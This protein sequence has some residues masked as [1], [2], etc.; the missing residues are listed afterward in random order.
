[1]APVCVGLRFFLSGLISGLISGAL[2]AAIVGASAAVAG[3]I[4]V[5]APSDRPFDIGA[6]EGGSPDCAPDCRIFTDD[7]ISQRVLSEPSLW[8]SVREMGARL[9]PSWIVYPDE[10]RVDLAIDPQRWNWMDYFDRYT[11]VTELA[12][13]LRPRGYNLRVFDPQQPERPV[14][15]YTCNFDTVP[16]TCRLRF[17]EGRN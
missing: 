5:P 11:L 17:A 14:A 4:E 6:L 12:H 3:A 16:P 9:V 15:S 10:G 8:W 1:M 13:V 7:D 2:G